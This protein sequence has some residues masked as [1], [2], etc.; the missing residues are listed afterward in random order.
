MGG[1][2]GFGY[3]RLLAGEHLLLVRVR[4]WF[5]AHLKTVIVVCGLAAIPFAADVV[6]EVHL[7][8]ASAS[9]H[10]RGMRSAPGSPDS[11]VSPSLVVPASR[12]F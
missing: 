3:D 1:D 12:R 8:N 6:S 2:T 10:E 7:R 5:L 9:A 4:A 11:P